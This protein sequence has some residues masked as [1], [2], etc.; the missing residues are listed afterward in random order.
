MLLISGCSDCKADSSCLPRGTYIDANELLGPTSAKI[1][2]DDD[3]KTLVPG[4][5]DG[6]GGDGNVTNGFY[7]SDWSDGRKLMLTIE[8]Y[9]SAGDTLGSIAEERTMDSGGWACGVHF[10]DWKNGALHRLN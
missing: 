3:C 8:V 2:F 7:R 1:C 4:E 6:G 5:D 9:D 10:Y